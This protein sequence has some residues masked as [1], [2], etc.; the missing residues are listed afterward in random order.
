MPEGPSLIMFREDFLPFKGKKVTAVSGTAKTIDFHR[1]KTQTIKDIYTFGK[2]MLLNFGD[3]LT[4]RIHF[5][6]FGNYLLNE[7]KENR[8]PMLRLQFKGGKFINFYTCSMQLIE[9]TLNEVYDWSVDVMNE[10]WNPK[11]ALQ[12]LKLQDEDALVCDVLLDQDIFA[13]A[14]NII[15]NEA[16]Y[17]A[18]IQPESKIK[19][20]PL[21]KRKE[22]VEKLVSFTFDFLKWKREGSLKKHW[23]VYQQ[24]LC[25]IH[26]TK[27]C[28]GHPGKKKRGSIWC[29]KCQK[30]Y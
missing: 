16:L 8:E 2:H 28:K 9:Q 26:K 23:N 7:E 10:N 24:K 29:E 11:Q 27:L 12:N 5:L 15:K 4:L 6:M 13:G 20:L 25:P 30:L 19:K 21:K 18:G 22:L 17:L 3:D 1:L 14:G